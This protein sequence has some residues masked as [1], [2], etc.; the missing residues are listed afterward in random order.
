MKKTVNWK[1]ALAIAKLIMTKAKADNQDILEIQMAQKSTTPKIKRGSILGIANQKGGAGKTTTTAA[2]A[3]T[4]GEQGLK[5]LG[6]DTDPQGNLSLQFGVDTLAEPTLK[7]IADV[8]L[9][10][11]SVRE[12]TVHTKFRGVDLIPTSVDLAKVEIMLPSLSG[13]DLLLHSALE[14]IREDYDVIIIDSPPN[15]GKF[16]IN[17]LNASDYLLVPVEGAWALRSVDTLL[18]L[19]KSNAK[20]YKLSTQFLGAFLTKS[21]RTKIMRG[22]REE[23]SQR[24]GSKLLKTEIRNST[25]ARESATLETPLPLYATDSGIASD[26]RSLAEE[27]AS[28]LPSN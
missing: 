1:S 21:D 3:A 15:L 18:D 8:Y 14:E 27:V 25:L 11:L 26:Y 9:G 19:V 16:A 24:F 20:V 10:K 12:V 22:I 6:V 5:V 4:W 28:L 2:L 13:C 7:T 17:V 23:A